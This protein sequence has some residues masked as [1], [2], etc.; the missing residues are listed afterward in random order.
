[1]P[2]LLLINDCQIVMSEQEEVKRGYEQRRWKTTVQRPE[3]ISNRKEASVALILL[4]VVAPSWFGS[5]RPNEHTVALFLLYPHPV[6]RAFESTILHDSQQR[7]STTS[8]VLFGAFYYFMDGNRLNKKVI[9]ERYVP[10]VC[11]IRGA[12]AEADAIKVNNSVIIDFIMVNI[13]Y[14]IFISKLIVSVCGR[15][16]E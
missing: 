11:C 2:L 1:M 3:G 9:G 12:N 8:F 16:V 5:S 10:A 15:S 7:T 4:L 6:F 13:Y 14:C